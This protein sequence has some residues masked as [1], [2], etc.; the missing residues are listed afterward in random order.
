MFMFFQSLLYPNPISKLS[1]TGQFDKTVLYL[2]NGENAGIWM[3][4]FRIQVEF[5]S[6]WEILPFVAIHANAVLD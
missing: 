5:D 1:M 3:M 4:G 6:P 2:C